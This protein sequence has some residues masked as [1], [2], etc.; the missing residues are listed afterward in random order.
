MLQE[1][2]QFLFKRVHKSQKGRQA[3]KC[4]GNIHVTNFL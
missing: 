3:L 4:T 1:Y 2:A